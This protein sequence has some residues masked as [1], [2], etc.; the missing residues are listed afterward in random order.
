MA[1]EEIERFAVPAEVF[2]DL[3][4]QFDEVPGDVGAGERFHGDLAE[5]AVE[6]VAELVENRLHLAVGEQRGLAIHRRAHVADDQAEVRLAERAGV[7][8]VHPRAAALGFARVPVGVE[9]TEVGGGFR[10]V[11]FVELAP[12]DARFR[13]VGVEG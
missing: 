9:R 3:R 10:I 1:G 8:R 4:G 13:R 2:H 11:D 12:R 7:Q 6:Q 5:Q